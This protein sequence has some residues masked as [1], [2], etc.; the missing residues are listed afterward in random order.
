MRLAIF[1]RTAVVVC[2]GVLLALGSTGGAASAAGS[3]TLVDNQ[4]QACFYRPYGTTQYVSVWIQGRW[5][6]LISVSVSG[7]PAGSTSWTYDSPIESGSSDGNGSLA[8]VAVKVPDSTPNGQY[9]A[10]LNA[11]D[12][13]TTETIPVAMAVRDTCSGY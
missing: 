6:R 9:T 10:R 5:S 11:T 1:S 7:A 2:T 3:W 13:S 4:Q 8:Y 12:G